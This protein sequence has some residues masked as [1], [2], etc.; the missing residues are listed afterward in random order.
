MNPGDLDQRIVIQG[1]SE[2]TDDFG[3]RVQTFSTLATLWAKVEERNG[4]EK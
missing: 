4:N 1:L 2:A 3:Q